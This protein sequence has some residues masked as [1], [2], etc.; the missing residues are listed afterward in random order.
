MTQPIGLAEI[1]AMSLDDR[2]ALVQ[3][4]WDSIADEADA[5]PV[6]E[7][8]QRELDRRIAELDANPKNVLTWEE[9][10]ARLQRTGMSLPP[11]FHPD[12]HDEVDDARRWYE[13]QRRASAPTSCE[14]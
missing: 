2:I 14:H 1:T 7:E 12:V 6:T 8:Q 10:K 4:I 11:V 5:F 3:A 9:F 13:R